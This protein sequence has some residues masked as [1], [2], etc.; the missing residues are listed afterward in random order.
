MKLLYVHI[1][2]E[3]LDQYGLD[4]SFPT[5]GARNINIRPRHVSRK[6]GKLSTRVA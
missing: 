2:F 4:H 1:V 3:L 5:E 6:D